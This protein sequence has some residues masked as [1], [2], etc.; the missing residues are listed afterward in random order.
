MSVT[1]KS[2]RIQYEVHYKNERPLIL[3]TKLK[4]N[5][6]RKVRVSI[7]KKYHNK[8]DIGNMR[9]ETNG[10]ESENLEETK[11]NVQRNEIFKIRKCKFYFGGVTPNYIANYLNV[12]ESLHTHRSLLGEL[13]EVMGHQAIALMDNGDE[14]KGFHGITETK[15]NE[16]TS[17]L[18][19]ITYY[20]TYRF[21]IDGCKKETFSC[22][23]CFYFSS[24]S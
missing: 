19:S 10:N 14:S 17:S 2:G 1:L 23:F 7:A 15:C 8:S 22:S 21:N 12:T 16:V 18:V 20:T 13:D 11:A 5:N 9:V 24:R 4:Y 3:I 6:G